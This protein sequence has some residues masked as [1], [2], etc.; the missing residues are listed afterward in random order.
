M[1]S[2]PWVLCLI[3]F[4]PP[5]N[6]LAAFMEAWSS[7][8]ATWHART[9][10]LQVLHAMQPAVSFFSPAQRA[11]FDALPAQVKVFRGCSRRRLHGVAWTTD[12]AVALREGIEVYACRS[13]FFFP[14]SF[15]K[16]IFS[17]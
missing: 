14:R 4:A 11:L 5:G 1:I 17:S 7:C 3:E 2:K 9:R 16:N 15:P 8:D 12:R 6:L 10:L 13:R